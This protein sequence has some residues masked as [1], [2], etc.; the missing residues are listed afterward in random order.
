MNN[1]KSEFTMETKFIPFHEKTANTGALQSLDQAMRLWPDPYEAPEVPSK[2]I[3]RKFLL[4]PVKLEKDLVDQI[5]GSINCTRALEQLRRPAEYASKPDWMTDELAANLKHTL[6]NGQPAKKSKP[7][8]DASFGHREFGQIW[9]SCSEVE[10][11]TGSEIAHRWTFRPLDVILV[12]SAID[13]PWDDTIFR[14]VA[15]SHAEL[16]PSDMQADDEITITLPDGGRFVVHLWLDY[17]ISACQL[18]HRIGTLA[19]TECTRLK[20]GTTAIEE[21]LALAPRDG[22]GLPLDPVQD[23][24]TMQARQRLHA[25]ASWLSATADARRKWAESQTHHAVIPNRTLIQFPS[26]QREELALA[27]ADTTSGKVATQA[28]EIV[29]HTLRLKVEASAASEDCAFVV[30]GVDDTPSDSLDGVV[31]TTASF[32]SK[33]FIHGQ[34][35]VPR[36]AMEGGVRLRSPDGSFVELRAI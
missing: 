30:Y 36:H 31:V 23:R 17:P 16:W 19:N 21:G 4:D 14:A 15:V 28:Y 3:L 11:W 13:M 25:C 26:L 9:H 2:A 6:A 7:T 10:R 18:A 27:A 12:S 20:I 24:A 8:A 33:P 1:Y 29:G 32:V 34:T 5:K 22:A 35:A